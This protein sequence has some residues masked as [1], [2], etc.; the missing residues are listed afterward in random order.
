M[1]HAEVEIYKYFIINI[2]EYFETQHYKLETIRFDSVNYLLEEYLKLD[3]NIKKNISDSDR[4]N[5]SKKALLENIKFYFENSLLKDTEKFKRD[6]KSLIN[7]ISSENNQNEENI[8]FSISA[9]HKK[10]SKVNLL[11]YYIQIILRKCRTFDEVDRLIECYVR[12]LM[13]AGYSLEYLSEW[14]KENLKESFKIVNLEEIEKM[15]DKFLSLSNYKAETFELI[16]K[17]N[18]PDRIKQELKEKEKIIIKDIEYKLLSDDRKAKLIEEIP[19]NTKFFE[20]NKV[21]Y[22]TVKINACDKYRAI[23]QVIYPIQEYS[24]IYK[25]IDKSIPNVDIKTCL[26]KENGIFIEKYL[27][28]ING[29]LRDLND[30]EKEDIEDF[31]MLRD[32]IRENGLNK[33]QIEDI[34]IAINL[35][36]NTDE[37]TVEN[38]LLN[39]W[40]CIENLVKSYNGKSIIG[41]VNNIIPK[42]ICMYIVKRKMN[43]LWERMYPLIGKKIEDVELIKCR[44]EKNKYNT[45]I[46]AKYLLSDNAESL[47]KSIE[48][49]LI[50]RDLAELNKLIKEPK[51]LIQYITMIE[52]SIEH[53]LNS[54]YRKRNDLVHNGGK[55]EYYMQHKIHN[56]QYYLNCLLGTMIFQIKRNPELTVGEILYSIEHTYYL[57]REELLQLD[58]EIKSKTKKSSEDDKKTIQNKIISEDIIKIMY[59]EYLYM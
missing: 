27:N 57:Y 21:T 44:T 35:I 18:L 14:W 1:G 2:R 46:F 32:S 48:Q 29:Y 41:K 40:A 43:I 10:I 8:L 31:L 22:C 55:L 39:N 12:E 13:Y 50:K 49:V 36:Y 37:I 11:N 52:K 23:E 15:I 53:S 9:I 24:K 20:S 28:K 59:V 5:K 54:I 42:V 38:K 3:G 6:I 16:L 34:E 17:F 19:N 51:S 7:L 26:I 25:I 4:L 58:G 47:Y 56:L 33:E 30:R 45:E